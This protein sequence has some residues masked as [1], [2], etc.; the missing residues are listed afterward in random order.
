ML[1]ASSCRD[2]FLRYATVKALQR[3]DKYRSVK[4]APHDRQRKLLLPLSYG[5]SSTV[6]LH[7]LNE[8]LERQVAGGKGRVAYELHVLVVE[9]STISPASPS[10]EARFELVKKCFPRHT[11]TTVPFHSIFQYDPDIKDAMY[12]FAGPNFV[13]DEAK[14]DHDR[15]EALRASIPSATSKDDVDNILLLRLIAACAKHYGCECV[16]WG[17]SD[18]RLAAKTLANVAK[19]RGASL[20][21]QVCDGMSPWG[22]QFIFPLRDL[23]K[24]EIQLYA[25]QVPSLEEIVIPEQPTSETMSNRNLSIDEL[26]KQYIQTHSEKYPGVMANVVRT[27]NKLQ[28]PPITADQ[29]RCALCAAALETAGGSAD[30]TPSEAQAR[31]CYGCARSAPEQVTRRNG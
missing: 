26:M 30:G 5:V 9:P 18:S 11:Y 23:Y 13:D 16:I 22:V 10:C 6:L 29:A 12:Q 3:I 1:T 7:M 24:S 17:D 15:L 8:H 21:W 19:G 28:Q 27:V 2:C 14:S 25:S 31:F 4:H 20:T